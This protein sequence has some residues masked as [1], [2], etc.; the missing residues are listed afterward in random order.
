MIFSRANL[1]VV[2]VASRDP[3]DKGLNGVRVEPD[4]STVAG[5]RR[6]ILAI[7]PVD[8]EGGEGG[9]VFFPVGGRVG[10]GDEGV[11]LPVDLV[12]EALGDLPRGSRPELQYAAVTGRGGDGVGGAGVGAGAGKVELTTVNAGGRERR[13]ADY[14][15]RER[16]P[17]WRAV[18]RGIRG[19]GGDGVVARMV[20]NR[21]DLIALLGAMDEA[22]PDKSGEN[23]VWIELGRGMVLRS[24]NRETGQRAVGSITVS[25]VGAGT[26]GWL[27][28]DWWEEGVMGVVRKVVKVLRRK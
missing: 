9:G 27:P 6:M 15:K 18:V 12:S 13:V 17:D 1:S 2:A 5:N 28:L 20:V 21:K 3:F 8:S 26:E 10:V 22:C 7:G 16:F 25:K 24:F 23:L 11:V 4:G 19:G 14:P